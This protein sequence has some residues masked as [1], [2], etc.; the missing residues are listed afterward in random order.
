DHLDGSEGA[1]TMI[2]GIGN[3]A[4]IVENAGDV[5]IESAGEGYDTVSAEISYTLAANVE[6]LRLDR[7]D[8]SLSGT[9]NDLDNFIQG[10]DGA[11]TLD[12]G[13]GADDLRGGGSDDFVFGGAGDD[14]LY[15]DAGNDRV[16]GASGQ[17][18]LFGGSGADV[19]EF[20]SIQDSGYL[21]APVDQVVDFSATEGDKLDLSQIDADVNSA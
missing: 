11:N 3:D 8:L 9:G 21:G 17:D 4:Y 15:G 6:A 13:L 18:T 10:N 14:A 19:F 20:R 2:G 5:V 16:V 7:T 1:D 12:G